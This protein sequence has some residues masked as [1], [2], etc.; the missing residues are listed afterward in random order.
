M[1]I[2]IIEKYLET[3]VYSPFFL[4]VGDCEYQSVKNR[5]CELGFSVIRVSDYCM[6]DD[7]LPNID[8]LIESIKS[9]E[10]GDNKKLVVIG[11]GEYISLIGENK[12]TQI[13]FRLKDIS[14][15]NSKIVLL[16][17]GVSTLVKN[18]KDD[19]RFDNRRFSILGNDLFDMTLT[20]VSSAITLP[21]IKGIKPLLKKF[22]DGEE[23]NFL[24]YTNVN[25]ENTLFSLK[26]IRCYYDGIK[27]LLNNFT[28]PYTSGNEKQWSKLLIDLSENEN[29]LDAVFRVYGFDEDLE[30]KLYS[31]IAGIGYK[32][33]LYFIA[34]KTKSDIMSNK[35]LRFV[36][37]KTYDFKDLKT[38][39]LNSLLDIKHTDNQFDDMYYERKMLIKG[40]PEPDI[41]NFVVN[42]RIKPAESI[43][44]LT[45]SSRTEREEII[46]WITNY[47]MEPV[48]E[49]IYPAL[50]AYMGKYYFNCGEL[51][52]V[53]T[54][55]FDEYKRQKISNT[56]NKNFINTVEELAKDR[57]YNRLTSRNEVLD[58]ID[59][60]DTYLCWV[61][62]LG[63]EYLAF[64]VEL[65]RQR[66][67]NIFI[68]I[69]R[70]E[71]PTITSINRN[72]FD[73]WDGTKKEKCSGLDEIKHKETGGYNFE[74]NRMPIHLVKEL[75]IITEIINKA[76]TSLA[77]RHCTRYL[78]VSDHGASRLAVLH[79]KEEKYETDT[80][81]EHSGRCCEAFVNYELPLAA[82]ENGYIVLADYGRFKGS[83]AANVEVHGG[84]SLEEV[85][86]PIIELS[87][88]DSKI[89]VEIVDKS[90]QADYRKGGEIT[91][92]FNYP[93]K[94]VFIILNDKKY[95]AT[96]VDDNHYKVVLIDL[97]RAGDYPIDI[98]AGD[99]LIDKTII[100]AQGKS[101]KINETFD[102]LF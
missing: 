99:N 65:A 95:S 7:K 34:L 97:K 21:A 10:K 94:D 80:K 89:V 70:A 90:I 23:G 41:A 56:L 35:Y 78:I 31:N 50:A 26:K 12:G 92:F 61:D 16:L 11:I 91:L 83:R 88:K 101:A 100:K 86:I 24:I 9:S 79:K 45:D 14:L 52:N 53:L 3:N 37:D 62:A 102:D 67:L 72:F 69:A 43:Y 57:V 68:D 48:V 75:D 49:K 18:M 22:E 47:G 6:E 28:L 1:S 36:L 38:N 77:L 33:W 2:R 93:M 73:N 82:E 25:L 87:L 8:S 19:Q 27:L 4:A 64:I 46:A 15:R 13:L 29:S 76:S 98:Y 60:K 63:V 42:N 84:A 51:S 40:F 39:L 30:K 44:R 32:N 58:N 85:V 54:E 17:R 81:G 74:N 66:D 20:L 71:L 5:L 59:K 96:K 55:Y